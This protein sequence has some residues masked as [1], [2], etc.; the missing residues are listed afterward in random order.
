MDSLCFVNKVDKSLLKE[1]SNRFFIGN[2]V[3][4]AQKKSGQS[5]NERGC[6]V[7]GT[8]AGPEATIGNL[9]HEMGHLAERE[10]RQLKKRPMH[11]WGFKFGKRMNLA[12]QSWDEPQTDQQVMREARVWSYQL[13]LSREFG[14]KETALELCESAVYL[15]AFCH[16]EFKIC[17]KNNIT[18]YRDREKVAVE[19]LAN[20]VEDGA[21]IYTYDKFVKDWNHRMQ[22]LK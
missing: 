15:P 11:S 22:K 21:K 12:H 9:F 2:P 17:E 19:E 7:L 8:W 16:F 13:S 18:E 14:V 10:V 3:K 20:I 5:L 1:I 4:I 6:F